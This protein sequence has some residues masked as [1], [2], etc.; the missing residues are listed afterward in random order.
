MKLNWYNGGIIWIINILTGFFTGILFTG[1]IKM[2][3][4]I[5]TGKNIIIIIFL[6]I[7]LIVTLKLTDSKK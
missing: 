4:V 5:T 7:S 6:I 2:Y 1:Y 3:P